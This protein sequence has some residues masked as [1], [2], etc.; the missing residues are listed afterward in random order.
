MK[1]LIIFGDSIL[2]GVIYSRDGKKYRLYK[3]ELFEKMKNK[4]IELFSYCKMGFTIPRAFSYVREVLGDRESLAG[5]D[6]LLEYGGNDSMFDWRSVSEFPE[7]QHRPVTDIDE[8]ADTY[9]RLIKTL[10]ARG[11]CVKLSNL[12]PIDPEKYMNYISEGLSY[13]NILRW[14]GDVSMLYRFH[15]TYN[16]RIYELAAANDAEIVD[17]REDFLLSHNF[18]ELLCPDGIHPTVK[19]HEMIENIL[20]RSF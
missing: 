12:I 5:R 4:G 18:S 20:V 14:L 9:D 8:F 7:A 15:E 17:L 16:R 1:E 2:K 6:V 3:G 11:A 13:E 19:G 10:K